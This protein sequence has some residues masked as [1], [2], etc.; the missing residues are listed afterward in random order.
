MIRYSTQNVAEFLELPRIVMVFKLHFDDK[1]SERKTG[2][3]E[4]SRA[5]WNLFYCCTYF[6]FIDIIIIVVES[7]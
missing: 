6:S 1:P 5:R 7:V 4:T 3:H 2:M